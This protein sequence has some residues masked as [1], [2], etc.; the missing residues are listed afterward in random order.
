M[1]GKISLSSSSFK[2]L[3][4]LKESLV[5][6]HKKKLLEFLRK[7]S[8]NNVVL[9]SEGER[10]VI[11]N[12]FKLSDDFEGY[13]NKFKGI[14]LTDKEAVAFDGYKS[15]RPTNK[16][17]FSIRYETSDGFGN[18][19]TYVIKKLKDTASQGSFTFTAFAKHNSDEDT[20]S[21]ETDLSSPA[22]PNDSKSNEMPKKDEIIVTKTISFKDDNESSNILADFLNELDI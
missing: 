21:G 14:Q 10:K 7:K 8:S 4:A 9:L 15:A 12:Q 16:D 3:S 13:V 19:S 2:R 1:P 20:S 5:I 22:N 17:K 11:S 6:S 18:N